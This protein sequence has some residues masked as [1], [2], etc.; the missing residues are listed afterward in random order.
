MKL[1]LQ[2]QKIYAYEIKGKRYDIGDKLEYVKA[3]ID[4]ALEREDLKEEIRE[5]VRKRL[6]DVL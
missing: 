3:I 1:L 6:E 5:Y 2:R 4:F